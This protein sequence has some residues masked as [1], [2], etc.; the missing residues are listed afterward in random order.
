MAG[1]TNERTLKAL[2]NML[3]L[4][5]K[6]WRS[7]LRQLDYIN[8]PLS[9]LVMAIFL[10]ATPPGGGGGRWLNDFKNLLSSFYTMFS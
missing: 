3:I 10:G 5:L 1:W 9:F 4:V 6:L 7:V 2:N 8:G